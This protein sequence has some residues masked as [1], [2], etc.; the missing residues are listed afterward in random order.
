MVELALV[1]PAYPYSVEASGGQTW[2][3]AASS[4]NSFT[5]GPCLLPTYLFAHS[6][7]SLEALASKEQQ[8]GSFL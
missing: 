7:Y 4:P 3:L 5:A 6:L 2:A 8:A 1:E